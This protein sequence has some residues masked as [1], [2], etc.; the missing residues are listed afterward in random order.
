MT[1][2]TCRL[3][4]RRIV[5]RNVAITERYYFRK[6]ISISRSTR[7]VD[8]ALSVPNSPVQAKRAGAERTKVDSRG[9]SQ[10]MGIVDRWPFAGCRSPFATPDRHSGGGSNR[11][12]P[13]IHGCTRSSSNCI[14]D[15]SMSGII[16]TASTYIPRTDARAV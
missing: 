13:S 5:A 1:R 4:T 2:R 9:S 15:R 3:P 7:S 6:V 16:A 8:R 11:V 10:T 14:S 12:T